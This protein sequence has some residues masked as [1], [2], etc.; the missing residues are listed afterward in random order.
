MVL[1]CLE[2]NYKCGT[3]FTLA[4]LYKIEHKDKISGCPCEDE[5]L[6]GVCF[7]Q[8]ASPIG[9]AGV[10]SHKTNCS[11]SGFKSSSIPISSY[12]S[13]SNSSS[14]SLSN[15]HSYS[16]SSPKPNPEPYPKPNPTCTNLRS[17]FANIKFDITNKVCSKCK[18]IKQI[19]SFD[20]K[21]SNSKE[22]NSKKD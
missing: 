2:C 14:S 18:A 11:I 12:N 9:E 21:K 4:F 22:C 10:H 15:S 13:K 7:K 8:L 3:P 1:E 19:T 17:S 20:K 5:S 16:N 6:S